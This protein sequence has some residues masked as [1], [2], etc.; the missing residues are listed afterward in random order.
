M[1][2]S[3]SPK[4]V[5]KMIAV[6]PFPSPM[7]IR[8]SPTGFPQ[9]LL[10]VRALASRPSAG[11]AS[12]FSFFFDLS[13]LEHFSA[14]RHVGAVSL[15]LTHVSK[16]TFDI[17]QGISTPAPLRRWPRSASNN[18]AGPTQDVERLPSGWQRYCVS[19]SHATG[20]SDSA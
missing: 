4:T 8:R 19:G 12:Q 10:K 18:T 17:R 20:A 13:A 9:D 5:V 15:L 16:S 1:L 14:N 6:A 11:S 2:V 7:G 3:E